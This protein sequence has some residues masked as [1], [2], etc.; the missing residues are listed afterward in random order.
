MLFRYY[1]KE[2]REVLKLDPAKEFEAHLLNDPQKIIDL[3]KHRMRAQTVLHFEGVS[4]E[5]K[6]MTK[7]AALFI[8]AF[9]KSIQVA[10]DIDNKNLT[11]EQ[12]VAQW[13]KKTSLK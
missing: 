4:E 7:G 3:L 6:M 8:K 5:Q 2:N 9:L 1:I 13:L 12:K 11:D 10:W